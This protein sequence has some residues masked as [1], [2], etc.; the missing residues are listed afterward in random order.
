MLKNVAFT[1]L[2]MHF[3]TDIR[4]TQMYNFSPNIFSN[5]VDI[6]ATLPI[7]VF[8]VPGGPNSKIPFGGPRKPV[9]ISL[10][11]KSGKQQYISYKLFHECQNR[12]QY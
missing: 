12:N 1:W 4:Q 3:P 5:C 10:Y 8:P 7:N 2:A 9:N 6:K 11:G